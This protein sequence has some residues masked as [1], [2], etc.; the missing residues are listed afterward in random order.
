MNIIERHDDVIASTERRMDMQITTAITAKSVTLKLPPDEVLSTC[1]DKQLRSCLHNCVRKGCFEEARRVAT[2]MDDREIASREDCKVFE[3]NHDT[4]DDAL[5]PF[6][7]VA[8]AVE[9]NLRKPWVPAGG[10]ARR[11]KEDPTKLW[12]DR[13]CGMK[14]PTMNALFG[15]HVK[16]AGDEPAFVLELNGTQ[17]A[18]YGVDQL[19]E[20]FQDWCRLSSEA[21]NGLMDSHSSVQVVEAQL[22]AAV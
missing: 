20:A 7:E 12:I 21:I 10:R 13:Y 9:D 22:A 5:R 1:T 19:D 6:K 2:L 15:C 11:A 4:V 16:K 3:W 17:R 14:T 8:Q 18:V